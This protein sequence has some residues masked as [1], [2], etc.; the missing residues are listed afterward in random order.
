MR[1]AIGYQ[2]PTAQ[3]EPFSALC[4]RYREHIAEVYFAWADMPSGRSPI[5]TREGYTDWSGIRRMT[6]DLLR[7][8]RLGIRLDLLFNANCYGADAISYELRNRVCSV[9][10]YLGN[11]VGGVDVVTTTSPFIADTVKKLYPHIEV[12]ASVNLGIGTP[13]AMS[14][15]ADLFDSF[16][17]QREY[18]RDFAAIKAA[19]AWC[20]ANGKKLYMLANS[21]CLN[22]CTSHIFHDNMVAHEQQIG[23][24]RNVDDFIPYTCWRYLKDREHWH[25]VL[26]GSWVR[27]ED[28][29]RYEDFFP[30]VKLATRMHSSPE[31]VLD[32]YVR[33]SFYGNLPDLFEPSFSRAFAPFVLDNSRIPADFFRAT[34]QCAK[35]CTE[36]DYCKQVFEN[37]LV[38]TKD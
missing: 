5:S 8:K 15:D 37:A 24:T 10:D 6:E 38:D 18:N 1:F 30:V 13:K 28:I 31:M 29:S 19:R 26:Q 27:P 20:D 23:K 14:Y 12:R 17:L 2:L 4:E 11:E 32:A 22:F 34:S 33:G 3:E 21:G 35:N 25:V 36:C 16:Y 7:I 9:I